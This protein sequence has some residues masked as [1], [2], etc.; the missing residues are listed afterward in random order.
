[1]SQGCMS[2]AHPEKWHLMLEVTT[3][4]LACVKWVDGF[5]SVLNGY[6]YWQKCTDKARPSYSGFELVE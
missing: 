6:S 4:L 2:G 3:Y 5:S 1:M